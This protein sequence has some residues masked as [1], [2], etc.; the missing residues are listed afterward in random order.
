MPRYLRNT[1]I[2]AKLETTYGQDA[3]PAAADA[4]LVSDASIERRY[5]NVDRELIRGY[6]GGSEQLAGTRSV[7]I[8]FT[9]ELAGSGAAGTAPAWGRLLRACGMAETVTTG[10]RV[11]YNPVSAQ[12]ESLTIDYYLDGLRHKA[13]GCRGTF[14]LS[15]RIG[16]RPTLRFAFTGL[17]GGASAV[18]NPSPNLSAWQRPLVVTDP[19]TGDILLGCTYSTGSLSG[20]TAYV[21]RGLE[22]AL[23]AG[24]QFVP[25]LGGDRVEITTRE[26]TGRMMLDLT[27]AQE[28]TMLSDISANTLVSV[29]LQHGSTPGHIIVVFAPAVQRI[30]PRIEELEGLALFSADLRLTPSAGND[31]LRICAR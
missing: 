7:Q 14:E 21:S 23:G 26:A 6:L 1:V 5:D 16:E 27:A 28:A 20:G 31:E 30:N 13:L 18:S 22:L 29:G 3:T 9:V 12:F 4:L 19:N 8:E 25:M 11:E 2:L 24:V 10:Q 15:E 17:D